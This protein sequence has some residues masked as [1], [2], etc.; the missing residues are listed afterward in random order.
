MMATQYRRFWPSPFVDKD[1]FIKF[2]A[3]PDKLMSFSR[4]QESNRIFYLELKEYTSTISLPDALDL[5]LVKDSHSLIIF[6]YT[7]QQMEKASRLYA[8]HNST[9]QIWAFF[10]LA[11]GPG[12]DPVMYKEVRQVVNMKFTGNRILALGWTMPDDYKYYQEMTYNE[13]HIQNM[14]NILGFDRPNN[15]YVIVLDAL[16]LSHTPELVDWLPSNLDMLPCM[17][18]LSDYTMEKYVNVDNLR[19]FV[20]TTKMWPFFFDLPENIH[21]QLI[22]EDPKF[23]T[24][25]NFVARSGGNERALR[26]LGMVVAVMGLLCMYVSLGKTR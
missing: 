20:K 19:S 3:S 21:K 23:T 2:L 4:V 22:A 18:V 10:M 16:L 25:D 5:M 17:I 15:N 1:D 12:G 26:F 8:S 7:A 14:S 24:I 11:Q 9:P 13:S 6:Y